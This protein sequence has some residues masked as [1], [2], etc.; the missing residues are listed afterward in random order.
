MY[1]MILLFFFFFFQAEDGIRDYKVTGV[2]TCA[3]PIWPCQPGAPS[4][5][6]VTTS[7][8][9]SPSAS[10][11]E[12]WPAS[13][14]P[15]SWTAGPPRCSISTGPAPG[16]TE[17]IIRVRP[18]LAMW[19]TETTSTGRR[20]AEYTTEADTATCPVREARAE[21][22]ARTAIEA[23]SSARRVM[24]LVMCNTETIL[25]PHRDRE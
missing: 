16:R 14:V 22:A 19:R 24:A 3:L 25:C 23:A 4:L 15:T 6:T 17:A 5:N 7:S 20:T 13:F 12:T 1:Y 9:P 2:Q 8:A 11:T 21:D 18:A 10:S